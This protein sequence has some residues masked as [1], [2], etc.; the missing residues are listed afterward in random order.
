MECCFRI[1]SY[2]FLQSELLKKKKK[3]DKLHVGCIRDDQDQWKFV[4]RH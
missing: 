4:T 3:H 1:I 2:K